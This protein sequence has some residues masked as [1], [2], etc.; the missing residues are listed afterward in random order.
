MENEKHNGFLGQDGDRRVGVEIEFGK[1]APEDAARATAE[2]FGGTVVAD[3]AHRLEVRDTGV[4]TF[5]IELDWRFVH[6]TLDE[7]GPLDRA[8]DMIGTLGREVVPTELVSPPLPA[9]RMDDMDRLIRLL[10]ER[11]AEG[12]RGGLLNGFGLHLNPE[13]NEFDM[14][15]ERLV[16]MMR[17]YF[18]KAPLLRAAI[19]VDPM[20]TILPFVEP[21]PED[22]VA[23]VLDPDYAPDLDRL[24]DDYIA[25]NPTRNR[26]LDML[27]V[28]THL[29]EERVRARL[30]DPLIGGRPTFHWRLPNADLEDPEWTVSREWRRWLEVERL[31]LN[32]D[33]LARRMAEVRDDARREAGLWSELFG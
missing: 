9:N 19:D 14:T 18:L 2:V 30:D 7:G 33:E 26:E 29:D 4:G 23:V 32:A 27:T 11:G 8:R 15:A 13:L 20:R 10:A 5:S 22:Y 6:K 3:G 28:F 16:A 24:I 31:S 25:F 21:F 1:L 17:A 12:T